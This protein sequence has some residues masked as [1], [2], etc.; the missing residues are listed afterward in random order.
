MTDYFNKQARN[1]NS[2]F[3][4][5]FFSFLPIRQIYGQQSEIALIVKMNFQMAELVHDD[6]IGNICREKHDFVIEIYVT[7][8]RAA[9]PAR[10]MIFL[11]S[12]HLPIQQALIL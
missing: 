2:Y 7:F 6:V 11:I 4:Q 8:R 12:C 10:F 1:S 5:A 9:A 3:F